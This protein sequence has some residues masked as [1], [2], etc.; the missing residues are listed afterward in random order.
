ML[1]APGRSKKNGVELTWALIHKDAGHVDDGRCM[2]LVIILPQKF[3]QSGLRSEEEEGGRQSNLTI[4]QGPAG[5]Q[6]P[7]TF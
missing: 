5:E 2:A 7:A 1:D 4:R 3:Q 6:A